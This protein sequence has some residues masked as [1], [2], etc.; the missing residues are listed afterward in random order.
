[1]KYIA[2]LGRVQ[3]EF[4]FDIYQFTVGIGISERGLLVC[5]GCFAIEICRVKIADKEELR[6]KIR[7]LED[8]LRHLKKKYKELDDE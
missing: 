5:L 7:F 2:V 4:L 3:F 8:G 6:R 1:M